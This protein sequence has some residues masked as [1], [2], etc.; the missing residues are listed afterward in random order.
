MMKV[1]GTLSILLIA[2]L[3]GCDFMS[4]THCEDKIL[5]EVKSSD[6]KHV[7]ILYHRSCANDSGLYTCVN[8]QEAPGSLS[9]KGETQ[10]ILTIRGFHKI[11]AVWTS[12]NSLEI[13]SAGLQDHKAILTQ[14]S[15]WKTV[16][17]SYTQ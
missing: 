6:Q 13:K 11:S 4:H 3:G 10:P 8:L 2:T 17:I 1:V 15:N 14:E 12:S 5:S 7:A 16:S 9:S